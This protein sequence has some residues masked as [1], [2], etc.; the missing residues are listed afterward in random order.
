MRAAFK[1]LLCVTALLSLPSAVAVA[2]DTQDNLRYQVVPFQAADSAFPQ[3]LIVDSKNG[4]IWEF[5]DQPAMSGSPAHWG[6]KYMTKLRPG[7]KSGEMIES[8]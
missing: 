2:Q 6:L 8:H 1:S 7:R 5:F 4:D 3:V